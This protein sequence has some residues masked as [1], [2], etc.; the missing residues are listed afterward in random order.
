MTVPG[1]SGANR[2]PGRDARVFFALGSLFD[3]K[4][5]TLH[6]LTEEQHR[7]F[8]CAGDLCESHTLARMHST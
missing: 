6:K 2:N 8:T 4:Q 5:H 1:S 7:D 3:E